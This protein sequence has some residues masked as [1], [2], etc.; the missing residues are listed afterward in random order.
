MNA[1][2]IFKKEFT[3]T[4]LFQ[5]YIDKI[6]KNA[7]VGT[8]GVSLKRFE[9]YLTQELILIERK[10]KNCK[11]KYIPYKCILILRGINKKPRVVEKPAIRDRLVLRVI[12]NILNEVYKKD[13][14]KRMLHSQLK[15]L[16]YSVNEKKYNYV[17]RYDVEDFYPSVSHLLLMKIIKKRIRNIELNHLIINAIKNVNDLQKANNIE[18]NE[19]GVPQ[20]LSISNVLSNVYLINIDKKYEI[21]ND[22]EYYRFVDDILILCQQDKH[23]RINDN[24]INDFKKLGLTLHKDSSK[25]FSKSIDEPFD[26]LGYTFTSGKIGVRKK[27]IEKIRESILSLLSTHKYKKI[28]ILNC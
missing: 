8:D 25:H 9:K 26:Y 21:Q 22:L 24:I 11:Y 6:Q 15:R 10:V 13:L 3:T 7:T 1:S 19:K 28:K 23:A 20:G 2:E 14:E 5:I 16:I 4:N 12:F 27:S 17:L 18:S